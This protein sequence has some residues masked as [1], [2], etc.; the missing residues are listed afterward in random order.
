MRSRVTTASTL[1]AS[2]TCST[3]SSVT[4]GKSVAGLEGKVALVTGA[5]RGLGRSE[6]LE[7]ARRGV[8]IV[9]ND[10]GQGR[11]GED[12]EGSPAEQVVEEIRALGGEA[13]A[14][15]GDVAD[16]EAAHA[17]VHRGIDEWGSLDI[18][19]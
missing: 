6:A 16:F 8:R 1:P 19:V 10:V 2:S 9:V 4:R 14:D 17:M 3:S 13:V 11:F 7:L 12:E 5:G 15:H 18:L